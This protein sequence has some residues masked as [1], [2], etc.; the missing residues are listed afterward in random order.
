MESVL[1]LHLRLVGCHCQA[2]SVDE[3]CFVNWRVGVGGSG[4]QGRR[5]TEK[6]W[7]T[8]A[9]S[10]STCHSSSSAEQGAYVPIKGIPV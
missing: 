5:D 9:L 3:K 4:K 2:I 7:D 8:R 6:D 10:L 1:C